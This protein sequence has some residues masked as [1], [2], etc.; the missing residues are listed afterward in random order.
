MSAMPAPVT[1]LSDSV[2]IAAA[3]VVVQRRTEQRMARK[4]A[5][6]DRRRWS[7]LSCSI[8]AGSF[9]LTVGI[10]DVLH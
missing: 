6:R 1:E 2:R 7:I 8:L 3:P 9:A 5:R 10:L 4:E